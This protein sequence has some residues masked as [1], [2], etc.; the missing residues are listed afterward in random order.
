[1]GGREDAGGGVGQC[2]CPGDEGV[3]VWGCDV[4]RG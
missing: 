1:M 3:E 4:V 2:W